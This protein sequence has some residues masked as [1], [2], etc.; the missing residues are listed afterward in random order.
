MFDQTTVD[1]PVRFANYQR[2]SLCASSPGAKVKP[3]WERSLSEDF[4]DFLDPITILVNGPYIGVQSTQHLLVYQSPGVF[5]FMLPIT[6][7]APVVFGREAFASFKFSHQLQYQDYAGNLL[8]KDVTVPGYEQWSVLLLFKPDSKDFLSVAQFTGGPMQ[9]EGPRPKKRFAV[10]RQPTQDFFP[11]WSHDDDGEIKH[12]LMPS[13]QQ[14][15]VLLYPVQSEVKPAQ[16]QVVKTADGTVASR[17][18]LDF[19]YVDQAAMGTGDELLLV[20]HGKKDKGMRYFLERVDLTGKAQWSFELRRPLE[21]QPPACSRDGRVFVLTDGGVV[22][23]KDGKRIWDYSSKLNRNSW[24]SV[25]AD[26]RLI[27]IDNGLLVFLDEKGDPVF[28]T[29]IGSDKERFG[30]PASLD[31]QGRLYVAS[32]LK[33]YCLE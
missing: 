2:N 28:K 15:L 12:A 1:Y 16:V 31:R 14:K 18:D 24:M 25:A 20:G 10:Y 5:L 7:T 17:F 32:N 22:C 27:L 8:L 11:L 33:L 6:E 26:G 4:D 29:K 3:V 9:R 19:S 21:H 30:A 23:V 13:D